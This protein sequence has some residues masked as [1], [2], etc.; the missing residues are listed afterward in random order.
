MNE[1]NFFF[2]AMLQIGLVA[3]INKY[4]KYVKFSHTV[5]QIEMAASFTYFQLR[6]NKIQVF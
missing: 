3:L 1:K 4:C 2:Q 5:S 6:L